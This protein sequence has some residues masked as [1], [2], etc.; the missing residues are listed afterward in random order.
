[1]RSIDGFS[2]MLQEECADQLD[3]TG[4]DC[5]RRIRGAA[6]RMGDLIDDLIALSRVNLAELSRSDVDLSELVHAITEELAERD[7]DRH[8]AVDITDGLIARA[9]SGLIRAALENLLGNAWKFTAKVASPRVEFGVEFG[10]EP[11]EDATVYRIR[12]NGAGFDMGEVQ[13]L[14]TP[15]Q[16]LHTESDFPG[17]GIGLATVRRVFDRHGGLIWAE[18]GVGEGATFRFT[19]PSPRAGTYE[20]HDRLAGGERRE[21]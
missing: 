12:D 18:S 19:I 20:H 3:D 11:G 13:R 7:P 10:A 1:L 15:F 14:F 9:D 5:L 8:V 16:R 4:T 21:A 2:Q 6:H 17:T